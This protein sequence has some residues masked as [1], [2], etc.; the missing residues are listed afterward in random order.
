[1]QTYNLVFATALP[2]TQ[3]GAKSLHVFRLTAKGDNTS[4]WLSIVGPLVIRTFVCSPFVFDVIALITQ[5][6]V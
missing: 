2:D 6:K 4:I 5:N 3:T 1:M